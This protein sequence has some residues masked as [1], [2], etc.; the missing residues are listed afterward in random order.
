[1]RLPPAAR[2]LLEGQRA[3]RMV[4]VLPVRANELPQVEV[5][6]ERV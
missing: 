1:M 5:V 3:G 6:L 4:V 2:N